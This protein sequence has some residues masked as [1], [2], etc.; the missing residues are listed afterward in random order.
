MTGPSIIEFVDEG[1]G[2]S[3]YL[4][5]LGDGTALVIDPAR[6]PTAQLAEAQRQGL[7]VA[8]TADTHTHADYV[9]G[10]PDLASRGATFIAPTEA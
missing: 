9:S 7:S 4:V 8:F 5:D 2:H 6:L 3:S 1:L 10:S